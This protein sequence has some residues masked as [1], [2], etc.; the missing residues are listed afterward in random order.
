MAGGG[1]RTLRRAMDRLENWRRGNHGPILRQVAVEWKPL[2][3]DDAM[4]IE[5]W[6]PHRGLAQH[7]VDLPTVVRLMVEEMNHRDGRFFT[8]NRC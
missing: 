2:W 6:W 5:G 7:D 1:R 8:L 3:V 4:Q